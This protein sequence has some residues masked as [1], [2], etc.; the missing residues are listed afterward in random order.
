MRESVRRAL[1]PVKPKPD[2][3]VKGDGKGNKAHV[4]KDEKSTDAD[5]SEPS[6]ARSH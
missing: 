3:T 2:K 6:H 1:S 5:K 4:A